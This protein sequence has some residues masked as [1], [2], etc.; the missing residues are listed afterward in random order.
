MQ[1]F[2]NGKKEIVKQAKTLEE[3]LRELGYE[4]DSIAVASHGSFV[5]RREY[6]NL[7]LQEDMDLEILMPMQGG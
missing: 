1:L 5:P 3:L 2:V 6:A 7:C 4:R